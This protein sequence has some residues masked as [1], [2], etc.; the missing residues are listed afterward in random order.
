M[1][2]KKMNTPSALKILHTYFM[3]G[4]EPPSDLCKIDDAKTCSIENLR[5]DW[6]EMTTDMTCV[7][8]SEGAKH[9]DSSIVE[10]SKNIKYTPQSM[11]DLKKILEG[12]QIH[13]LKAL[14]KLLNIENRGAA[15]EIMVHNILKDRCDTCLDGT[16]IW[17][18]S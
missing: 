5:A 14:V 10:I 15:K 3:K 17:S 7:Y 1:P 2:N 16:K 4:G 11:A 12:S 8:S 6:C 18:Y 9:I 13:E